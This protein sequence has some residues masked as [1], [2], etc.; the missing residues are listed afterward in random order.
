MEPSFEEISIA[1]NRKMDMGNF[2]NSTLLTL[3]ISTRIVHMDMAFL[4]RKEKSTMEANFSKA[5]TTE[6]AESTVNIMSSKDSTRMAQG[7]REP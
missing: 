6:K 7:R 4:S 2:T 5:S 1:T 3:E